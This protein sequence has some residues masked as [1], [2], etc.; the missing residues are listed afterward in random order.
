MT[1]LDAEPF[2]TDAVEVGTILT[3]KIGPTVKAQLDAAGIT[4][5]ER[6]ECSLMERHDSF[7]VTVWMTVVDAEG[8]LTLTMTT[9]DLI[10]DWDGGLS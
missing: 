5:P 1:R 9:S 2:Y 7:N 10:V 4:L 6:I 3:S 8:P